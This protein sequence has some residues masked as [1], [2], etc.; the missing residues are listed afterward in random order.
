MTISR[1]RGYLYFQARQRLC[2]NWHESSLAQLVS[3]AFS[4]NQ[5]GTN[6]GLGQSK[7]KLRALA[8][9]RLCPYLSLVQMHYRLA[10]GQ[11]QTRATFGAGGLVWC[12]LEAVKNLFE[13]I[14]GQSGPLIT[15][16]KGHSGGTIVCA[17]SD[18]SAFWRKFYG[19]GH[20]V[21]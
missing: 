15:Y 13:H 5:V 11:A 9:H 19:V 2:L 10:Y 18:N 17:Q 7:E 8:L 21:G 3:H 14:W 4:N 1:K 6:L 12:L 16:A 20:E